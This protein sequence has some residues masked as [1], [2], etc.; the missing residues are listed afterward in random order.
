MNQAFIY[1][2]FLDSRAKHA[3]FFSP[4]RLEKLRVAGTHLCIYF[5][6]GSDKLCVRQ[7]RCGKLSYCNNNNK[8]KEM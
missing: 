8:T 7:Y 6:V 1:L 4:L 2:F 3:F 5:T